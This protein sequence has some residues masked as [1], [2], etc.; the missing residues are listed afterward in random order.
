[1]SA[2]LVFA[3]SNAHKVEELEAILSPA[4]KG[5]E[6]G[7]VARMSDFINERCAE[8]AATYGLTARE[9]EIL[10]QLARGR[11]GKFIAGEYVLSYN[12]VKTHIKHIYQK[13]GVH[14]RQEL[15]DAVESGRVG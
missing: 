2:R 10:G 4:W 13:V 12:T 3:T 1:M 15:L 8:L 6:A 11:D 14:S 5:F 7:C 9:S